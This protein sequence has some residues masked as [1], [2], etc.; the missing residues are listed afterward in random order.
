[1]WGEGAL[2]TPGIRQYKIQGTRMSQEVS[3]WLVNGL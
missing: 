3:T 1:M 2:V